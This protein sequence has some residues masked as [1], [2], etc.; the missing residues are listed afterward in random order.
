VQV[1]HD[2]DAIGGWAG[3]QH[4]GH[5]TYNMVVTL[6]CCSAI[7]LSRAN[8]ADF[9]QSGGPWLAVDKGYGASWR[10][11]TL[12]AATVGWKQ[13]VGPRERASEMRQWEHAHRGAAAAAA[14][15]RGRGPWNRR[16]L[17]KWKAETLASRL[18]AVSCHGSSWCLSRLSVILWVLAEM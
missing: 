1:E 7:C 12:A 8:C 3:G 2:K 4:K 5:V 11:T 9:R 14:T 10:A 17:G 15:A 13:G 16:D 18:R 6:C